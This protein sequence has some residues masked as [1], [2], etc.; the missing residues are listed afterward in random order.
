VNTAVFFIAGGAALASAV[1]VI[2]QKNPFIAAIALL[3]NLVSLATL[4]L[5]LQSD[6]VAAAQIMVYA[7]AIM[8]MFLFVI[9]YIGPRGELA[10]ERRRGV[11]TVIA[12]LAAGAILVE[13]A[14]V[15]GRSG[16][17]SAASVKEDFGSPRLVGEVFLT[18]YVGAFEIVSLLLLVAAI[19]AVVLGAGP[20]P[21]R[22][23]MD[24][25]QAK[26]REARRLAAAG[27]D[28]E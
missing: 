25:R 19:A 5:L 14:L 15:V 11:Q 6:F 10:D 7:G 2:T 8:V 18:K 17:A 26:V 1:A 27:K 13:V 23:K 22:V 9:A 12:C 3:G 28:A 16:L 21:S 4:Y 24:E 20:R